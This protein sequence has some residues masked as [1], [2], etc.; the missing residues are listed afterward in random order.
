[1]SA[2]LGG[3]S[4]LFMAAGGV[5]LVLFLIA[6]VAIEVFIVRRSRGAPFFRRAVSVIAAAAGMWL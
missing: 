6:E 3:K 1:M 5:M 2:R 4:D